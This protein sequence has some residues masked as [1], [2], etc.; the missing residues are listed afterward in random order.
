MKFRNAAATAMC[1][2]LAGTARVS[3]AVMAVNLPPRCS[4][5][6]RKK[7]NL[8]SPALS[9]PGAC[10]FPLGKKTPCPEAKSVGACV[11]ST[12]FTPGE[13]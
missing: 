6:K 2:A 4:G 10:Q 8:P 13:K 1:S 9:R 5:G 7:P 3:A 11:W 12:L